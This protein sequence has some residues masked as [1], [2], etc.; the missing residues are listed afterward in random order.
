MLAL[1][2]EKIP[3]RVSVGQTIHGEVVL[4]GAEQHG[5]V[6]KVR[7]LLQYNIS[8]QGQ[9]LSTVTTRVVELAPVPG[10]GQ[11]RGQFALQI[12]P[13]RG[14]SRQAG[15]CEA[16]IFVELFNQNMIHA[17]HELVVKA[18]PSSAAATPPTAAPAPYGS[19]PNASAPVDAPPVS[20][21]SAPQTSAPP[22]LS[23]Y[24]PL[25]RLNPTATRE[26]MRKTQRWVFPAGVVLA[27]VIL[28]LL[29]AT[30]FPV[31][32][33][34]SLALAGAYGFVLHTLRQVKEQFILENSLLAQGSVMCE[35][36][37]CIVGERA[38]L[39]IRLETRKSAKLRRVAASVDI[40][41]KVFET[42]RIVHHDLTDTS[43]ANR[44]RH[45]FWE[46]KTQEQFEAYKRSR[47]DE[48][49]ERMRIRSFKKDVDVL[50]E[51][52][53][54]KHALTIFTT[55]PNQT[56]H[57]LHEVCAMP[58]QH[59]L[60]PVKPGGRIECQ[61]RLDL[62]FSEDRSLTLLYPLPVKQGI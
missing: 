52:L 50:R 3:D 20:R 42:R 16:N 30:A 51:E 15:A 31:S 46:P 44:R 28:Y 24:R 55:S 32:L 2:L 12:V 40:Y 47:D 48:E 1:S 36:D 62:Y 45:G 54:R 53:E 10:T 22:D 57:R 8:L 41:E 7:L 58:P 4:G 34:I 26:H 61:L 5:G 60:G 38:G 49:L 21:S 9:N 35:E 56:Q 17:S 19:M 59:L 14:A 43:D 11:A 37:A 39:F 13:L 6:L 23:G 33:I 29:V 18:A 25:K 27:I